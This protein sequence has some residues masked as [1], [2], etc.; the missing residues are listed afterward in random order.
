MGSVPSLESR[1]HV[2]EDVLHQDLN[3]EAV[4]LNLKTGMYFGLDAVGTRVWQ[5]VDE[6]K[7][8]AEIVEVIV[9]EYDV[10]QDRCTED[11]LSLVAD[12]EQRGLVTL[13]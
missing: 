10:P 1:I 12:M 7:S 3:G 2:N 8:L 13:T 5:L 6:K 4:L 9:S 11:V